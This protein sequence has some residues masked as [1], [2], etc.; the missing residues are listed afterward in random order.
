MN[1]KSKNKIKSWITKLKKR[2]IPGYFLRKKDGFYSQYGQDKFVCDYFSW[3]SGGTFL[4][5]GA[6]DGIQYSN[7]YFLEKKLQWGGFVIEANP[8]IFP[9][10]VRNR[11]CHC[12][13]ACVSDREEILPFR[14]VTGFCEQL[15]GIKQREDESN[16]KRFQ[17]MIM[18]TGSQARIVHMQAKTLITDCP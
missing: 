5:I 18:E 9:Q 14:V 11:R 6:N 17:Q 13:Q 7:T 10:L 4:D 8:D 12:L 15:S 2:V 1:A 16:E 3:K